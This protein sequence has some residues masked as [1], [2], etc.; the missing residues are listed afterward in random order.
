MKTNTLSTGLRTGKVRL[1]K[2]SASEISGALEITKS[3]GIR[4]RKAIAA[5]TTRRTKRTGRRLA[6]GAKSTR[7]G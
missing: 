7:T 1:G 2:A 4:A 3:D 5:V 6:G